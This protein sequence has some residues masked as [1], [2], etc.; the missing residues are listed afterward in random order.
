MNTSIV[1]ITPY[2]SAIPSWSGYNYQGKVALYCALDFINEKI[3]EDYSRYSLELEWYEDFAIKENDTYLSIHQVKSYKKNNLSEYKDAIWN[4]LGKSIDKNISFAYLHTSEVIPSIKEIK[5]KLIT[6]SAPNGD[7]QKKYTPAYYHKLLTDSGNYIKAFQNFFIYKY[8][9]GNNFCKID[10]LDN[11]IMEEIKEYYTLQGRN[12]S[13]EQ[14]KRV[15]L[16]L[17]GFLNQHITARHKIEQEYGGKIE[18]IIIYL[19]ELNDILE[20]DWE[21]PSEEF[22]IG[23]LRHI[24]YKNCELYIQILYKSNSAKK[25]DLQRVEDFV[26][27]TNMLDNHEFLNFCKRITP[28]VSVPKLDTE[29]FHDLIPVSGLRQALIVSLIEIKQK[30]SSRHLF[31]RNIN[32]EI[33]YYLPTTID[34]NPSAS[35]ECEEFNIGEVA[36]DI[37]ENE[38]L[39]EFLYEVDAMISKFILTNSLEESASN[40]N[41]V[42]EIDPGEDLERHARFTKIKKI[43]IVDIKQAKEDLK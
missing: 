3:G 25:E 12:E 11:A 27:S 32:N 5:E 15:F 24:F 41:E 1:E 35:F 9:T 8:H 26:E 17:L 18:P 6:L 22:Y 40:I 33:E 42:P 4:L 20:S 28:N 36:R 43:R 7:A 37:L 10:E 31:E 16:N 23:S 21:E 29:K 30:L 19:N 14:I 13:S 39:D 34:V 38:N 2:H